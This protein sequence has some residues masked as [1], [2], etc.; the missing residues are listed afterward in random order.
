VF[1]LVSPVRKVRL[2]AIVDAEW[3]SDRLHLSFAAPGFAG[4][5]NVVVSDPF[6]DEIWELMD[7]AAIE[8][9]KPVV[10]PDNPPAPGNPGY[11]PRVQR[12]DPPKN[13][14]Q[15]GYHAPAVA[16]S[17]GHQ[18]GYQPQRRNGY[19]PQTNGRPAVQAPTILGDFDGTPTSGKALFAAAKRLG[20][21]E[22]IDLIPFLS[23]VGKQEGFAKSMRDWDKGQVSYAWDQALAYVDDVINR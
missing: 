4:P 7:S 1:V 9:A 20:E 16:P 18:N 5:M 21:R 8:S 6:A 11:V 12:P 3:K 14:R 2:N 17:N 10:T 23:T 13:G 22:G 15:N 19:Q